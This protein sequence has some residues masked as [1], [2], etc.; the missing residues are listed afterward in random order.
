MKIT[1][2]QI[3]HDKKIA[4][5]KALQEF[6]LP[7]NPVFLHCG[8]L[9]GAIRE[10]AL[11][12]H[13]DDIDIA[14]LS[15]YHTIPEVKREMLE[16]YHYLA[17]ANQL[18]KYFDLN[19]CDVFIGSG[20]NTI[21]NINSN[22]PGL[23]QAHIRV[24]DYAFDMWTTWVDNDGKFNLYDMSQ[25]SDSP[26]PLETATIYGLEFPVPRYSKDILKAIYGSGWGVP[27]V[28]KPPRKKFLFKC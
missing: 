12:D 23:G 17:S 26:L 6:K 14:Y 7:N 21:S 19:Y 9:L 11:I 5:L 24:N 10:N 22:V 18:I 8:T 28:M 13:D 20:S 1:F 27:K 3:P 25:I 2:N 4:M 15:A 16:I